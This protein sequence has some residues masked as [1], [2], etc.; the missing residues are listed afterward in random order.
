MLM[1]ALPVLLVVAAY[2]LRGGGPVFTKLG[3][4]LATRDDLL[5]SASA[6]PP[7]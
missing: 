3:Q 4:I 7:P 6:P 2:V 1:A 5:P